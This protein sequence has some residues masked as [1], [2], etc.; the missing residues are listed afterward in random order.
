MDIRHRRKRITDKKEYKETDI[1]N[2]KERDK[3]MR[4]KRK[5]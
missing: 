3:T 4:R 5:N 1:T 2:K